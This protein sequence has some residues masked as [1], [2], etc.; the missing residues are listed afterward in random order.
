MKSSLDKNSSNR[1]TELRTLLNK[2]AHAYYVL[3]TPIIEDS[4]YDR[5]Y[6]E[7]LELE[8]ENPSLQTPDSP[9]QR[10]GGAPAKKFKSSDHRIPL[11][12]LDNAFNLNELELWLSKVKK[13]FKEKNISL[14]IND[15]LSIIGELKIDGNAIALSYENGV[16]VKAATRG[17]GSRGEEITANVRTI[18]SIPLRLQINNPP[19]WVE[20]RG[21]AFIP[22]KIFEEINTERRNKQES[23]F[24]NPRNACAGTLRQLNP[25]IVATRQL[26]FFAYTV[27]FPKDW[28]SRPQ[29]EKLVK[30]QWEA[31]EW[32]KKTGFKVNPNSEQIENLTKIKKFYQKWEIE[33]HQLPYATDGIVLKINSFELQDIAGS[34]QKAPRWAIAVKYPAEEAPSK[35]IKLSY[36]VGRTGAVTPVAEFEPVSLA[37]TIVSR[38]TLHNAKRLKTLNLHNGD[39][40][41]VRK[42]GE[43]IPEVVRV[44]EELRPNNSLLTQLPTNCPE[45]ESV[46]IREEDEA[47]TRCKN[48]NCPAILKGL[49]RHWVSKKAMNIEGLGNKLIEQLVESGLVDS[50]ADIYNLNI[51]QLSK[52]DRMGNKSAVKLL[53]AIELSKQQPWHRQ[54]YGLGIN[55]VGEVNAKTICKKFP[56]ISLL[57]ETVCTSPE[58]LTSLFGIGSE[59][60]ES[61]KVWFNNRT[62]QLI[63]KELSSTGI[64][65]GTI[66]QNH[67]TSLDSNEFNDLIKDKT[68]VLTG[69]LASI[70]RDSV[71]ELIEEAG[72]RISNSVSKKTSFLVVGK[73]PG[74]KLNKGIALGIKILNEAELLN[75][76]ESKSN[77]F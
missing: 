68:F 60:I 37:G 27:V 8:K 35:L 45:C 17:D 58:E 66:Q 39:T 14:W 5:L 41:V 63:V 36:Q 53:Q 13:L 48:K 51:T 64:S 1:A 6:R 42:A 30:G 18:T 24:A 29:D 75:L 28:E 43:I 34:T 55:N 23:L 15:D 67:E 25:K 56:N 65:L 46:L 16:L 70:T 7:L 2:A 12:S 33:R 21:E 40:I 72:G 76:L 50:I 32:L 20:I 38:A 44:I 74:S 71:K 57:S 11:L 9:S 19:P 10:L 26:D 49:I 77:D 69:S 3:D 47:V 31:L 73:E 22:N 4:V 54:L 61:L 62:N 59:I 52:M